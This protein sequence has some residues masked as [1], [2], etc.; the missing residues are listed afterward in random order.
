MA[1]ET[2][3]EA[4]SVLRQRRRRTIASVALLGALLLASIPWACT[5]GYVDIPLSSILGAFSHPFGSSLSR[6]EII[7]LDV[8]LPRIVLGVLVGSA[9]ALSGCAMQG[10]FK[11]PMA[12]PYILGVSSGAAFGAALATLLAP[13][14]PLGVLA[15]PLSAFVFSTAAVFTVYLIA[16]RGGRT[17]V[18]TL[19]L[20][21]IAIGLFFSAAVSFLKYVADEADLRSIV[22][23]LMGGL[24]ASSWHS[25]ILVAAPIVVGIVAVTTLARYLNIMLL[26]EEHALNLGVNVEALKKILLLF[27]SLLAASAV[28]VVGVVGFVGLIVPH[29]TRI[30]VGPDHRV[31]L[32]C[33]CLAGGL[34]LVWTDTF[35]RTIIA[36]T[37]VPV[38]IITGLFGSLFFI[39]LLRRR[40][41][42]E[43]W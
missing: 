17:P 11:N 33:S 15:I 20:A 4:P 13:R 19:L 41:R 35:A 42:I 40:K 38:G 24:W 39:F 26:G 31:L 25:V 21:G 37:E 12:S 7:V 27:A 2:S 18:E 23:W 3:P 5:M 29:V 30:I 6:Q 1:A 22:F 28:C 34:F 8:R 16:H 10:L 36:P 9:L 43:G 32:P 14:L